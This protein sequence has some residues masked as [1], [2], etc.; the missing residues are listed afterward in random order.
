MEERSAHR[1]AKRNGDGW[2]DEDY[3]DKPLTS[4]YGIIRRAKFAYS[5]DKKRLSE[6]HLDLYIKLE[7]GG[8]L[9]GWHF[10]DIQDIKE[11]MKL[12]NSSEQKDLEGK[13]VKVFLAK[14]D[15]SIAGIRIN[16]NLILNPVDRE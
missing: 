5:P 11:V 7:E 16:P 1:Y 12:T 13:I 3:I 6:F 9:M 2:F 8:T 4:Q 15:N 10:Y 14:K